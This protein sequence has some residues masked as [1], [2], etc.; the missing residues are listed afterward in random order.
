LSN[1]PPKVEQET[2]GHV[3]KL[4][5]YTFGPTAADLRVSS[6][7]QVQ[8]MQVE[9]EYKTRLESRLSKELPKPK[10]EQTKGDR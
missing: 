5:G 1:L 2:K 8:K 6:K 7:S 4:E 9:R 10:K 3:L